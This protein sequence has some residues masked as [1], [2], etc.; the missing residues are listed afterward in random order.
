MRNILNIDLLKT[1]YELGYTNEGNVSNSIL[2]CISI[3][4]IVNPYIE[5]TGVDSSTS[6]TDI[7]TIENNQI[8]YEIP[9]NDY[10]DSGTFKI[11]VLADNYTSDYI[12][13]NI[14]DNLTANDSVIV[15]LDNDNYLIRKMSGSATTEI[16]PIGSIYLSINEVNPSIYFGGI[17]EQIKDTFL[18][19]CGNTYEAGEVGGE[20]E[21]TLTIAE[22]PSHGHS[23]G[24]DQVAY[25]KQAGTNGLAT[26]NNSGGY[27]TGGVIHPN[28]GGE[29]HNN[30][31]PY[32]AV[33]MWKRIK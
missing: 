27:V 6:I 8:E 21:H 31:P 30:M 18:L 29:A 2:L 16:Y 19:A 10:K 26:L 25:N 7:L 12:T 9:F 11:R 23:H 14:Q 5:V 3:P 24:F 4:D 20:A 17:W 13:F 22:M 15:K 32:L 28:G 1:P 33:Y